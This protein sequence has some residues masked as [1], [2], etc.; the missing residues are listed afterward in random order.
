MAEVSQR[1]ALIQLGA[2]TAE[3]VASVLEMFV[4]D[5]IERGEVTAIPEDHDPFANLPLEGIAASVRY[6]NGVTGANVFL[7]PI[8]CARTLAHAMGADS[9]EGPLDELQL[10]AVGEACNQMLASAAGATSVV[11]GEEIEISPPDVRILDAKTDPAE[12]WG[13]APFACS[14]SFMIAGEPCRLV[15]L[16]P[17]TFIVRMVRAIGELSFEQASDAA[18]GGAGADQN[19][20]TRAGVPITRTLTETTLRLWAELGR[21]QMPLGAALQL[22]LGAVV[23]LD[24]SAD[25]PVELFVNG[26]CFGHGQLLVTDDGEWAIEVLSVTRPKV[27]KPSLVGGAGV[28]SN[29]PTP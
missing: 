20:S 13:S 26:L 7:L 16:V 24:R 17:N 5:G 22:P 10:S 19:G 23:D 2:S 27:R 21:T 11:I 18:L 29:Q 8:G 1:D 14:T 25:A 28:A 12:V 6:I 3:A 9:G 15:Q 4:P